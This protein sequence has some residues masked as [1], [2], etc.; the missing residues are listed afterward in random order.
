MTA[1]PAALRAA[2]TLAR[3]PRPLTQPPP[4][5]V[6]KSSPPQPRHHSFG[7]PA[8]AP[9][10]VVAAAA[11]SSDTGVYDNYNVRMRRENGQMS[12]SYSPSYSTEPQQTY[13]DARQKIRP[14]AGIHS[15][16]SQGILLYR[17]YVQKLFVLFCNG[18]E[19][20]G[21]RYTH[22]VIVPCHSSFQCGIVT[23]LHSVILRVACRHIMFICRDVVIEM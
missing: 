14:P 19:S 10:G 13:R 2:G 20:C 16:Y 5:P 21:P 11:L 6:S 4:T 15:Q 7:N 12:A 1:E 22:V 18:P 9:G 3:E 23:P 8:Q 17:S